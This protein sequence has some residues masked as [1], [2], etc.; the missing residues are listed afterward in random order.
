MSEARLEEGTVSGAAW[1]ACVPRHVAIIMD[2]NRRWAERRRLPVAAGH[3]AGAK[4]VRPV[5]DACAE[6]GVEFLT[7]F[8][9]STEN[10][11]R[12]RH[13]IRPLMKLMREFLT[14]DVEELRERGVRLRV[15]GDRSRFAPDL[16]SLMNRAEG[17]TRR[18][19]GLTLNIA[20]GYGGRWDIA[21][22]ARRMAEDARAG[23]LEPERVD[24]DVF[25]SYLNLAGAGLP[26]PDLC[27]RTGGD[28]RISNFLLWDIAYTELYFASDYWP[29]FGVRE[30]GLAF[31]DFEARP[32][33]FGHG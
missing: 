12:P 18:N 23:R 14:H 29:D 28:R 16:R 1:P 10:W 5:A 30:L 20:A 26:A 3:R 7:L 8:A 32:R 17:L 19:G 13:E 22:A 9:F 25:A 33:R 31:A 21:Q 4:N 6:A 24:D 2:G 11:Q 27:I 15:I